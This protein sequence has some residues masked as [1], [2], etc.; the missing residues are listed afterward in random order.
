MSDTLAV[1]Q[2]LDRQRAVKGPTGL[3]AHAPGNMIPTSDTIRVSVV[4]ENAGDEAVARLGSAGAASVRRVVTEGFVGF[5][6][7]PPD[8]S[9]RAG[10]SGHGWD[11]GSRKGGGTGAA[12]APSQPGSVADAPSVT[13]WSDLPAVLSASVP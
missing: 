8:A 13:V 12:L 3:L 7:H 10:G 1:A 9:L 4:L 2:Q 11:F 6:R 5:A